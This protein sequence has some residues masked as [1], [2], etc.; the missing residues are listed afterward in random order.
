[1]LFFILGCNAYSLKVLKILSYKKVFARKGRFVQYY[2]NEKFLTV[3]K[4]HI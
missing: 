3:Q 2:V 4:S 1:M